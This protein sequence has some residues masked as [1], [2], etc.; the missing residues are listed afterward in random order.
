[1]ALHSTVFKHNILRVSKLRKLT[2]TTQVYERR[3]E[4]NA[5]ECCSLPDLVGPRAATE[6]TQLSRFVN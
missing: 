1:M 3:F 6:L 2:H 5:H 4:K